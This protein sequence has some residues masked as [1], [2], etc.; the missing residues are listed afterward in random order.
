VLMLDDA[1]L[2]IHLNP[3]SRATDRKIF[4]SALYF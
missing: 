2:H 4:C 1:A 3:L